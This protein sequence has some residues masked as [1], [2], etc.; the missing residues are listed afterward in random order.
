MKELTQNQLQAVN[1][2]GPA[3]VVGALIGGAFG[4]K[5]GGAVSLFGLAMG[6]AGGGPH[7]GAFIP[8]VVPICSSIFLGSVVVGAT[9]GAIVGLGLD[10]ISDGLESERHH[11]H[12]HGHAYY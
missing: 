4:A 1:G 10:S 11:Q 9:A 5:V 8:G 7:A 12:H 2:G 6:I 3:M